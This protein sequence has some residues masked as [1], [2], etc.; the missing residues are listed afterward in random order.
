MPPTASYDVR[1]PAWEWC[2]ANA[3]LKG[4]KLTI[5][6]KPQFEFDMQR[7]KSKEYFN[8]FFPGAKKQLR[9]LKK[10]ADFAPLANQQ[11]S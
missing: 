2:I 11:I 6:R 5:T 3:Q 10:P 1:I 4:S 9:K 8:G 7:V